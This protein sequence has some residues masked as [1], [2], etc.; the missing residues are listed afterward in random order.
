M[1]M[2]MLLFIPETFYQKFVLNQVS[3]WNIVFAALVIVIVVVAV[4]VVVF[5][6]VLIDPTNLT[7]K[8]GLNRVSN[9]WDIDDIELVVVVV[10]GWQS[11]L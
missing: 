7:L 10:E 3:K 4:H 1:T 5:V 2:M 6:M 8:F 11:T 9:S